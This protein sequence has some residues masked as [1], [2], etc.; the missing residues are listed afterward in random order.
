MNLLLQVTFKEKAEAAIKEITSRGKL[1]IIVGGTGSIS[2]VY[3][4]D[5]IIVARVPTIRTFVY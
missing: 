1:P 5:F 4:M 2:K 3:Y